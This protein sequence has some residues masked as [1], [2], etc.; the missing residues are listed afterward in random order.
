MRQASLS[1]RDCVVWLDFERLALS[2][3]GANGYTIHYVRM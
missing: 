1:I 2:I 3:Y